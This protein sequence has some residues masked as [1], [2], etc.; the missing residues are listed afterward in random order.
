MPASP[1]RPDAG[2]EAAPFPRL[3][4]L[5]RAAAPLVDATLTV[6]DLLMRCRVWPLDAWD[7]MAPADRPAIHCR[8]GDHVIGW[9]P[10]PL[11][12]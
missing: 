3:L 5:K 1:S 12:A 10:V 6:R 7:R 11:L 4:D 2:P 8:D 9:E